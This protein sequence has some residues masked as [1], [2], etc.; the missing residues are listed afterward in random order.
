M[1]RLAAVNTLTFVVN[2]THNFKTCQ[3]VKNNLDKTHGGEGDETMLFNSLVACH[4]AG[5][6]DIFVFFSF[7]FFSM[8]FQLISGSARLLV[9]HLTFSLL[10]NATQRNEDNK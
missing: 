10:R 9:S 3:R 2:Q 1:A 8:M 6:N 4:F 7:F 5:S